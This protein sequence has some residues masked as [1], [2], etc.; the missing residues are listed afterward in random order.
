MDTDINLNGND[1]EERFNIK[2]ATFADYTWNNYDYRPDFS[3][4]KVLVGNFGKEDALK[5]L[6]FNDHLYRFVSKYVEIKVG[7]ERSSKE[8]PYTIKESDKNEA[9][10]FRKLTDESF[11]D[12]ERSIANTR[13]LNQ[14]KEQVKEYMSAYDMILHNKDGYLAGEYFLQR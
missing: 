9:A 2:F 7:M 3:L 11:K 6:K 12:L 5:L 14:I 4:Y 13:L 10:M 1:F 8:K